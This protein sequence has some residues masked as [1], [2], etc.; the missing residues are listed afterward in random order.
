MQER[1][2]SQLLPPERIDDT[3]GVS[4]DYASEDTRRV[5]MELIQE[6][7]KKIPRDKVREIA[8]EHIKDI[9][10]S[11]RRDFRF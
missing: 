4:V 10:S 1:P 8:A 5:G 11:N 9:C 6:E 7:L 3:R 2:D